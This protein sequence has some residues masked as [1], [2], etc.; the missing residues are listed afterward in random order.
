MPSGARFLYLGILYMYGFNA[1][2]I[3]EAKAFDCAL[4]AHQVG[5]S[6]AAW[7]LGM[8]YRM[9]TGVQNDEQKAREV[10]EPAT[11]ADNALA[12]Y[13]RACILAFGCK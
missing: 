6:A 4:R 9:G 3:N 10:L 8:C 2:Q 11:A 12:C 1:V 13:Q 5:L 7:L